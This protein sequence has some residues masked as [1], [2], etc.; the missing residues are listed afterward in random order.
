MSKY[1]AI[2]L[3]AWMVA[4]SLKYLLAV[5]SAKGA[6]SDYKLLYKSGDMPSSHSAVVVSLLVVVAAQDGLSSGLF[7]VTAILTGIVLYDALNVRRAVGE[8]GRALRALTKGKKPIDEYSFFNA[9]GHTPL[10]VLV[11]SLIGL[12]VAGI[13]LQFL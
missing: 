5:M 13:M 1:I 3:L 7:G 4:Q 10:E 9:K 6:M 11:G 12:L 2:P 8:Q